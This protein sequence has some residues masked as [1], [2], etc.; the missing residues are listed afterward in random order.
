M[1]VHG[2]MLEKQEGVLKRGR[3]NM[4]ETQND[5]LTAPIYQIIPSQM[6]T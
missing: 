2:I 4:S 3:K 1:T 5:T 6:I